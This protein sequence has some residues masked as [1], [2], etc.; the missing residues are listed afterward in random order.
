V[1]ARGRAGEAQ[2]GALSRRQRVPADAFRAAGRTA[3]AGGGV[4][5]A[6]EAGRVA[7]LHPALSLPLSLISPPRSSTMR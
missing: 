6:E 1:R 2:S 7:R 3:G 5:V 4:R